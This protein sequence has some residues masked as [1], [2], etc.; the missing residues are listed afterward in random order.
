MMIDFAWFQ[1]QLPK[2]LR[3]LYTLY[4]YHQLAYRSQKWQFSHRSM[5][6]KAVNDRDTKEITKT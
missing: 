5:R 3:Q 1:I 6:D 2:A 4:V